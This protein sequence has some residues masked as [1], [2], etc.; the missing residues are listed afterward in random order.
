MFT[1]ESVHSSEATQTLQHSIHM[2]VFQN[3]LRF[4]E[5]T[6]LIIA[7]LPTR[8]H[9]SGVKDSFSVAL[10]A[11]NVMYCAHMLCNVFMYRLHLSP[12]GGS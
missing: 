3:I 5:S 9:D 2:M 11:D 6:A 12:L 4:N 7:E 10:D 1:I 8:K